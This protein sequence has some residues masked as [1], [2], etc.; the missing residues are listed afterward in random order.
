MF[1]VK[2]FGANIARLRKNNDM[3]QSELADKLNLTRQAVSKYELGDSYPDISILILIAEIF[4]I[5][6]QELISSG[7]PTK[8][9]AEILEIAAN[10]PYEI[11]EVDVSDI[12]TVAPLLKPSILDRLAQGLGEQGI[13]IS[14]IVTLTEFLSDKSIVNLLENATYDTINEE[15]IEK[16]IPFLDENAKNVII[17]KIID[18]KYDWHMLSVMLP[19]LHYVN[20][21]VI[22]AAVIDGALPK[23]T[24]NMI[25]SPTSQVS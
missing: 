1:D 24:L 10:D 6:L 21:A 16:L 9:E 13:D 4:N 17:N 22:E 14:N 5:T 8:G 23:D 15:L 2:K 19:Y 12:I 7:E 20:L 25:N 18:G 11:I 3:T